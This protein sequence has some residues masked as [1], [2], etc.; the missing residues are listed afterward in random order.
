MKTLSPLLPPSLLT[1]LVALLLLSVSPAIPASSGAAPA[2]GTAPVAA[3]GTIR[4][5]AGLSAPLTDEKGEKWLPSRDF[6]DGDTMD[7]PELSIANTEIPSVY[8]S[9]RFGMTRFVRRIPNGNYLVKLHFAV[10]YEGIEGPRQCVFSFDVE[11]R[12]FKDFD[13]FVRAGGALNAYVESIPV[14]IRDGDLEIKFTGL[15]G[16]PTISAI[17]IVPQP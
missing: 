4:I 15:A 14:A 7:R 8:R 5:I 1:G 9:E 11:G 17:E 16:N 12:A 10:T 6:L 2:A 13:L 3:G